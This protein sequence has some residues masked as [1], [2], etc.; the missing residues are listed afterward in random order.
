M[1][2]MEL[3]EAQ[4]KLASL[5]D[6]AEGGES[7]CIMKDGTP[8]ARIVAVA[9]PQIPPHP[10]DIEALRKL[11]SGMTFQEESAG[12]FMRRLRDEERY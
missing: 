3:A 8:V 4:E 10:I 9:R 2:S 1:V 12:D 5:V 6:L 11:T 7:V